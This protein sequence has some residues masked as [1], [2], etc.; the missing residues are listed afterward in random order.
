VKVEFNEQLLGNALRVVTHQ[1]P[2]Y[3]LVAVALAVE[4]GAADD[5]AGREGL[6][7]AVEHLAYR[8]E[9]AS[10]GSVVQR[11][12]ALGARYNGFTSS[13]LTVY[14]AVGPRSS[15]DGMLD[16]F[17]D[18]A[19]N[20][21]QGIG[22][23]VLEAE[24][25]VLD[26]ERR[27]RSENGAPGQIVDRLNHA[28]YGAGPL[29]RPVAGTAT[30]LRAITLADAEAF[31]RSHYH[32]ERMSLAIAGALDRPLPPAFDRFRAITRGT[33][34]SAR[35]PQR[36]VPSSRR[37]EVMPSSVAGPELW[38]GF[39]LPPA[40]G[41]DGSVIALVE[42]MADGA[43][44][45]GAWERHPN[46]ADTDVR[47][48]NS[49]GAS[50]LVCRATL[51]SSEDAEDVM[52]SL[53][54][55]MRKGIAARLNES[56]TRASYVQATAASLVL[57]RESL[58]TRTL[59]L[60]M[61]SAATRDPG[62]LLRNAAGVE[63]VD[64][65]LVHAFYDR[66]LDEDQARAVLALPASAEEL[67]RLA[68]SERPTESPATTDIELA[69]A[70]VVPGAAGAVTRTLSNGLRVVALQRSGARFQTTLLGF[71]D[72]AA[73]KPWAV[74]EAS[75]FAS[76]N[77]VSH[78]PA[79]GVTLR[80][81]RLRDAM[82]EIARGPEG[83]GRVVFG[84]LA[85]LL[86]HHHIDWKGEPYLDHRGGRLLHEQEPRAKLLREFRRVLFRG[87]PHGIE[88]LTA[89]IDAVTVNQL[90]YWHDDVYRAENGTLIVVGPLPPEAAIAA[91]N[92]T[93]GRYRQ[94]AKQ[95][96]PVEK[97]PDV[98]LSPSGGARFLTLER[99][100]AS[101]ADLHAGCLLNQSAER[102]PAQDL[103]AVLIEAQLEDVLRTK[104]GASYSISARIERTRGNAAVLSLGM[105]VATEHVHAALDELN[106]LFLED[107]VFSGEELSHAKLA[108]IGDHAL[109]LQTTHGVAW[110]LFE[111]VRLE[112]S[113]DGLD[114]YPRRVIDTNLEQVSREQATCRTTALL[115]G[116]GNETELKVAWERA[117]R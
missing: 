14:H 109:Q 100:R 4:A 94:G 18:L 19:S 70:V 71:L 68:A 47:V 15:L 114:T 79:S 33:Q 84:Q 74:G 48:F 24:R 36:Q 1:D 38:I 20:P 41:P 105:A 93:L 55:V 107:A 116:V 85:D 8:S 2:S 21:I 113:L 46:V 12:K 54:H 96:P 99:P 67:R 65:D 115:A 28:L 13:D 58:L 25:G 42:W 75:D 29:G 82:V 86:D 88:P 61:G 104:L 5:P 102:A 62:L 57:E 39:R 78:L 111:Q 90:W 80:R 34:P 44:V 27:V 95:K 10:G 73:R 91:V 64:A 31:A 112:W 50:T 92:E 32:A 106:R 37:I 72:G 45:G 76:Q 63:H 16:V 97:L 69:R 17:A 51:T 35:A 87:H 81:A 40:F 7:H 52:S 77:Y 3:P 98:D 56:L 26:N 43:L 30:S 9:H 108:L 11:L 23:E 89:E 117:V 60:V 110:S 59:D 49:R 103:L 101:Q 22:P 66:H 83:T 53:V 6:A